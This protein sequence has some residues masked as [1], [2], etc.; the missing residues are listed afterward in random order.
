M[1]P[2][3]NKKRKGPKGPLDPDLEYIPN[4]AWECKECNTVLHREHGRIIEYVTDHEHTRRRC[5]QVK[6]LGKEQERGPASK[7]P[8]LSVVIDLQD[9]FDLRAGISNH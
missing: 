1:T 8:R 7:V 9:T 6:Q 4:S 3:N 2:N 5:Y